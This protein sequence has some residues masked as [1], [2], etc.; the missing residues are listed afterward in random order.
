MEPGV[1]HNPLNFGKKGAQHFALLE[2]LQMGY[3]ISFDFSSF[4][5]QDEAFYVF[6]AR[7][8]INKIEHW[9]LKMPRVKPF[10]G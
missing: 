10:Y 6:D 9:K 4:Q 3:S 8:V 2:H 7:D 5:E 1:F